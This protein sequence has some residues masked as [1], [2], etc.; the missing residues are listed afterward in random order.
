MT[1]V[2]LSTQT[3]AVDDM[4][5]IVALD[6]VD[7]D[8]IMLLDVSSILDA[9]LLLI[10]FIFP[11]LFCTGWDESAPLCVYLS[12]CVSLSIWQRQG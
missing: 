3:F 12:L 9:A 2:F 5:L 8:I 1:L 10:V 11:L 6:V 7:D 4:A